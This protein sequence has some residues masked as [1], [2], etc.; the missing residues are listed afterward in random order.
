MKWTFK[1]I[2]TTHTMLRHITLII[3]KHVPIIP[4]MAP[5]IQY[6]V[7]ISLWFVENNHL[8]AKLFIL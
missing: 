5:K 7:L 3:E 8:C 4:A 1:E 6:R 2:H